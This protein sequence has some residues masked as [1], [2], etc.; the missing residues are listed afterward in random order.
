VEWV[1]VRGKTVEVAVAAALAELG[2]DDPERA[3]VEVLQEP[4]RGFLG[5]GGT[6]AIVRVKPKAPK[7]RRRRRKK[8]PGE[9]GGRE[10]G[11][12]GGSRQGEQRRERRQGRDRGERKDGGSGDAGRREGARRGGEDRGSGGGRVDETSRKELPEVEIEELVPVVRD[13][14]S[15]LVTAFGLEGTVD[16]RVEEDTIVAEVHGDQTEAL[17]GTRGS[18]LEAVHDL[19]KTVMQ[20]KT[21]GSAR[22]RLDIAGYA[23]RRRQALTIYANQLIA[24]VLE[25]GGELMLDPMSAADRKVIHDAAAANE[26]IRSYSEGVAPQRYVVLSREPGYSGVADSAEAQPRGDDSEE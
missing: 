15:G 11:D 14:L 21:Q 3:D 17:V 25:E 8:G 9:T 23:E 26:G 12:R 10:G 2:I 13:F 5:M 22:L 18:V 16:V 6:P 4:Q 7:K 1:E 19:T 20:R 24:Q